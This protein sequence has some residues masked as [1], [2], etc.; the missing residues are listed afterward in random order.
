MFIC[1]V[2]V[3][4]VNVTQRLTLVACWVVDLSQIYSPPQFVV[5]VVVVVARLKS[6]QSVK[7]FPVFIYKSHS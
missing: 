1:D 7:F 6:I 2:I 3:A 4:H 5:V